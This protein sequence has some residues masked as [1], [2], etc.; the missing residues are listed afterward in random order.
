METDAATAKTVRTPA[1]AARRNPRTNLADEPHGTLRRAMRAVLMS[2]ADNTIATRIAE[3]RTKGSPPAEDTTASTS[4]QRAKA[5][6]S[7][8]QTR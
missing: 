3:T 4:E 2:R 1:L 5:R 7:S 6:V 8:A